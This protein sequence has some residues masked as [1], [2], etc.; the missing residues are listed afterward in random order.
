L[1]AGLATIVSFL[2]LSPIVANADAGN[3]ILGSIHGSIRDNANGTATVFVR[4]Q[5]NWLTHTTDCNFDR[6]GTGVA[7]AWNDPTEP[8][9]V[10]DKANISVQVGTSHLRA[11]DTVN[12]ID[13]MIH[14]VDRGNRAEG[15]TVA[16]V[17]FP[18]GQRFV[19]PTPPRPTLA[20]VKAWRGGCGREPLSATASKGTNPD[21]SHK[22]CANGTTNCAGNPWGSWGYE[23]NSGK[24]Y[25]HTFSSR[26]DISKVCVIFYD[27]HGGGTRASGHFQHVLAGN[28]GQIAVNGNHDNSVSTNRFNPRQG[29][30]CVGFPFLDHTSATQN[31]TVGGNI[32]DTAFVHGAALGQITFVQFHLFGPGDTTCSGAD[33]Y[34]GARKQVTGNGSVVSN[35]FQTTGSG[36]YRWT[37]DLFDKSTGGKLLYST[38]CNDPGETSTAGNAGPDLTTDAGGAVLF[39]G[40]PP[41][42]DLQDT[43]TLTG[44]FNPTGTITFDL[45]GPNDATCSN[46]PVGSD[47]K[48][49][50]GNGQYTG[51]VHITA[52]GVY[53]WIANYSGDGNND[54]T[55]NGCNDTHGGSIENL[56]VINPSI[57]VLKDPDTPA[58]VSGD[59]ATFTIKVTNTGDVDLSGV[60]VTD[61]LSP[62]CNHTIG[63]LA[64]GSSTTYQCTTPAL[65]APLDNVA[66]ACGTPPV[67]SQVCDDDH[68]QVGIEHLKSHSD[69]V[70]NDFATITLEGTGLQP[71]NGHITFRLYKGTCTGSNQIYFETVN[72]AGDGTYHSN[73]VATLLSALNQAKFGSSDTGGTYRWD[74]DYSGDTHGNAAINGTC[75][76]E[77][78]T[79]TNGAD[80]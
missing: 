38:G 52:P 28:T 34:S 61:P 11:G 8:G 10:V 53:R 68:G 56:T 66:T 46:A 78:F 12:K 74:I 17:G 65:T 59:T 6:A 35:N 67:G 16:G 13:R 71:L 7:I 42:N 64:A 76:T 55:A 5:W 2:V 36:A 75:G 23:K 19:D 15:Y 44:G 37:T 77:S 21:R 79:V 22:R 63:F 3:P 48:P 57:E 32:H 31:V 45:Y 69:F 26:E 4:G 62:D 40:N 49:V 30:N 70:P 47:T 25:S 39:A 41:G 54:A 14:P 43:A 18:S 50:S 29:A 73:N 72:V 20:N 80:A 27:V 51:T 9:Y 1:L 58:V 60:A 24:G 33:L